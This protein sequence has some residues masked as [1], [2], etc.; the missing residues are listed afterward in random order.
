MCQHGSN[1]LF[2]HVTGGQIYASTARAWP[3]CGNLHEQGS[4]IYLEWQRTAGPGRARLKA[5]PRT[6]GRAWM[7]KVIHFSLLFFLPI[8]SHI[9]ES[10]T[11]KITF[12]AIGDFGGIPLPPYSTY[13]Q[14]KI[15][16]VMGKVCA[17][18][19][20]KFYSAFW[21]TWHWWSSL[22]FA[23]GCLYSVIWST[24]VFLFLE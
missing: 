2:I 20:S 24:G 16:R 13:T 19:K 10:V 7:E 4:G 3:S 5:I 18:L 23:A 8:C 6:H 12:A 11:S 17:T 9:G 1:D 22:L 15:A 14:K 21:K